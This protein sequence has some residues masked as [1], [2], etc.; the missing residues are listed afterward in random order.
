MAEIICVN[1][2]L[3]V[4]HNPTEQCVFKLSVQW[5]PVVLNIS[6]FTDQP[7]AFL[8]KTNPSIGTTTCL[9][10]CTIWEDSLAMHMF[11]P[12]STLGEAPVAD[13]ICV[14]NYCS[15]VTHNSQNSVV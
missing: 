2:C 15:D 6:L 14:V 7:I 13:I 12:C 4:T 11:D 1:Y 10:P 8:C 9:K 3:H 5:S